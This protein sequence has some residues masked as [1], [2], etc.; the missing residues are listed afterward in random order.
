MRSRVRFL[1]AL[2]GSCLS[3][4]ASFNNPCKLTPDGK[5]TRGRTGELSQILWFTS[6]HLML[7]MP[8]M[9]VVLRAVLTRLLRGRESTDN[10][11]WL[12][13]TQWSRPP[14]RWGLMTYWCQTKEITSAK[15]G[16][17]LEADT[18]LCASMFSVSDL[19]AFLC[20]RISER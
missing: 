16:I 14:L 1:P 5:V 8:A 11:S 13:A 12:A 9:V 7:A 6:T 20:T 4:R 2:R 10:R 19:F 18:S 15:E 3:T 17:H